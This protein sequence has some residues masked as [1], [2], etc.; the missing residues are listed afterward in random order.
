MIHEMRS[1][2]Y[3]KLD[4]EIG[5]GKVPIDCDEVMEWALWFEAAKDERVVGRT[6]VGMFEVS[7][8]F[9]GLCHSFSSEGPPIL[10]ETMVFY[11]ERNEEG[12]KPEAREFEHLFWRGVS[13]EDAAWNHLE[14][15]R[16]LEMETACESGIKEAIEEK[17]GRKLR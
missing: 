12:R 1:G 2:I 3:Y 4:P 14:T 8:V 15:V 5:E 9:L 7:T 17:I 16:I 11:A 13:W 10:F 6:G